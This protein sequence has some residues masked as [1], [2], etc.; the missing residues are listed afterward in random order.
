MSFYDD[1]LKKGNNDALALPDVAEYRWKKPAENESEQGAGSDDVENVQLVAPLLGLSPDNVTT[2]NSGVFPVYGETDGTPVQWIQTMPEKP[3]SD[4]MGNGQSEEQV[5]EQEAVPS[6]NGATGNSGSGIEGVPPSDVKGANNRPQLG[7]IPNRWNIDEDELKRR[8]DAGLQKYERNES[9]RRAFGSQVSPKEM[10]R[11]AK[12]YMSIPEFDIGSFVPED[13][14]ADTKPLDNIRGKQVVE[15]EPAGQLQQAVKLPE[16]PDFQTWLAQQGGKYGDVG[17]VLGYDF[18]QAKQDYE[19][20]VDPEAKARR[21]KAAESRRRLAALGDIGLVIGDIVGAAAGGNV[22]RRGKSA[23]EMDYALRQAEENK[24]LQREALLLQRYRQAADRG[25]ANA[26]QDY[27]QVM[28]RYL[29]DQQNALRQQA[30]ANE[31]IKEQ[32]ANEIAWEKLR[33]QGE[34]VAENKRS[35]LASEAIANKNAESRNNYYLWEREQNQGAVNYYEKNTF[36]VMTVNDEE[37]R[38]SL[39][40]F[41]AKKDALL[42]LT[43]GGSSS[44]NSPDGSILGEWRK[45]KDSVDTDERANSKFAFAINR[46]EQT[47]G[48]LLRNKGKDSERAAIQDYVG[49]ILGLYNVVN[50]E[51]FNATDKKGIDVDITAFKSVLRENVYKCMNIIEE[52]A[53]SDYDTIFMK[54]Y[55]SPYT[56]VETFDLF[57]GGQ[58]EEGIGALDKYAVEQ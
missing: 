13:L 41:D 32:N 34:Q 27:A 18:K 2:W 58:N 22:N 17:D 9:V 45:I 12:S 24:N 31:A 30:L 35:N 43:G 55:R 7:K 50:E 52:V 36:P 38:V 1:L 46:L 28:Q 54:E 29:S 44:A 6:D 37:V 3:V 14:G 42:K 39:K 15:Q 40:G 48:I 10:E 49:A 19:D 56:G 25:I 16:L 21:E 8:I 51:G 47:A 5:V 4:G 57:P 11:V 33:L 26:R 53:Q 20:F 23:G